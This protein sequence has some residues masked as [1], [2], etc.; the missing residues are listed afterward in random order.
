[1]AL[2]SKTSGQQE[3]AKA[4]SFNAEVLEGFKLGQESAF[5]K[6]FEA[7]RE[8][9]YV[10][11]WKVVHDQETAFDVVQDTFLKAY[12]NASRFRGDCSILSWLR[13]IAMNLAIDRIRARKSNQALLEEETLAQERLAPGAGRLAEKSPEENFAQA[14]LA[15][16]LWREINKLK[17]DHRIPLVLHAEGLSYQEIADEVGCPLGTVMSRLYYARRELSERLQEFLNND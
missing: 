4:D 9:L 2:N 5:E 7:F 8:R 6:V 14:E 12:R 10:I 17:P 11:A 3:P 13:R 1:M 16:A 15:Q